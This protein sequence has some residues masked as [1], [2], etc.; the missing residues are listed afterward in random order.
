MEKSFERSPTSD[1]KLEA[2]LQA[3]SDL[4][5]VLDANGVILEYRSGAF[6]PDGFP[7]I[8]PKQQIQDI[9]SPELK[10]K[11]ERVL[12][13]VQQTGNARNLEYS[14]VISD[15]EHW[16]DARLVPTSN[17]QIMF[18]ARDV[19]QCRE[20]E[21]RLMRQMQR[22]SALRSIDLAIASGLDLNLLLSM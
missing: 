2:G 14:Q 1:Q 8:S 15:R 12:H 17:S 20:T 10:E 9:F 22:L 18:T 6:L 4:N 5:M 16:F 19:T 3:F 7:Q 13:S 21:N 11:F